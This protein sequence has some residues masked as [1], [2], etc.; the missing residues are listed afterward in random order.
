MI[1]QETLQYHIHIY[2]NY[3]TAGNI[4]VYIHIYSNYD[5]AGNIAILYSVAQQIHMGPLD[6]M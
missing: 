1:L 6:K 2:S 5:T 4:A 3:V